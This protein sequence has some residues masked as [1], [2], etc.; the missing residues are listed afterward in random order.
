MLSNMNISDVSSKGLIITGAV[1]LAS[2]VAGVGLGR[3]SK[4]TDDKGGDKGN[5][6]KET[7]KKK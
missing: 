6:K 7:K 5:T 2:L 4:K 3:W 1:I